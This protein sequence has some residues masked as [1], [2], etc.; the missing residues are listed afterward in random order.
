MPTTRSSPKEDDARAKEGR[1]SLASPPARRGDPDDSPRDGLDP[2]GEASPSS[3]LPLLTSLVLPVPSAAPPPQ[4]GVETPSHGS[5][6]P[7]VE[8]L[9][10]VSMALELL[11]L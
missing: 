11:S 1:Q 7:R 3:F 5:S 9:S 6:S 4:A 8:T 10:H 2:L